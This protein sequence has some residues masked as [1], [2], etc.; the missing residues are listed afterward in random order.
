VRARPPRRGARSSIGPRRA[1]GDTSTS[2][3]SGALARDSRTARAERHR[4]DRRAAVCARSP[5]VWPLGLLRTPRA[6]AARASHHARQRPGARLLVRVSH[7]PMVALLANPRVGRGAPSDRAGDQQARPQSST[8]NLERRW[9]ARSPRTARP[10]VLKP[11][12][13]PIPQRRRSGPT[14]TVRTGHAPVGPQRPPERSARSGQSGAAR[15][16][17]ELSAGPS[18]GGA[19][20]REAGYLA[21]HHGPEQ[22]WPHGRRRRP[23][24]ARGS[25]RRRRPRRLVSDPLIRSKKIPVYSSSIRHVDKQT[26]VHGDSRLT[27]PRSELWRIPSTIRPEISPAPLPSG[28]L[29]KFLAALEI[30][31]FPLLPQALDLRPNF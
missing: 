30:L 17:A 19:R 20:R 23:V 8:I 15:S 14:A 1:R 24:P 18:R 29:A 16:D 6:N 26:G 3:R 21:P 31:S 5:A 2:C 9:T 25:P 28:E 4:H 22:D 11:P 13:G 12:R 7:R 27:V 10:V